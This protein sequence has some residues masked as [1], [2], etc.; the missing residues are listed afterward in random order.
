VISNDHKGVNHSARDLNVKHDGSKTN[1][2]P[3]EGCMFNNKPKNQS[4]AAN[5]STNDKTAAS[6]HMNSEYGALQ[7]QDKYVFNS[8]FTKR[9]QLGVSNT[10][11]QGY[12]VMNP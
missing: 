11:H 2:G 8:K 4:S 3:F 7:I 6:T 12:S 5:I 9:G 10:H 1:L